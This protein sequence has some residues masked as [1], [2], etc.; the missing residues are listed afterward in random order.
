VGGGIPPTTHTPHAHIH[1]HTHTHTHTPVIP[2]TLPSYQVL[3]GSRD[4][5]GVAGIADIAT[6]KGHKA[7]FIENVLGVRGGVRGRG[8]ERNTTL[9]LGGKGEMGM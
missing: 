8:S 4:I 3:T 2:S 9:Q 7:E 5:G 1:T 6:R